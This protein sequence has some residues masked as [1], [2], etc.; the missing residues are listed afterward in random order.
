MS[1]H[2]KLNEVRKEQQIA[3]L[4][5]GLTLKWKGNTVLERATVLQWGSDSSWYWRW[6]YKIKEIMG[7][8]HGI[9]RIL[10][11]IGCSA[12]H[13]DYTKPTLDYQEKLPWDIHQSTEEQCQLTVH[14]WIP[15]LSNT[16]HSPA[17]EKNL[18]NK[19]LSIL[20]NNMSP[21]TW[22]YSIKYVSIA[23]I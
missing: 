5:M 16:Q 22:H 20:L 6:W 9:K 11:V 4:E 1:I 19:I 14:L 7:P 23:I 13:S 21:I 17:T 2:F 8:Y 3:N 18:V 10:R 12:A 15:P